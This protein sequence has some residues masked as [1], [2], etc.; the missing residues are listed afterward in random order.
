MKATLS[1][2]F[3]LAMCHSASGAIKTETVSV[4]MRDGIKLAPMFI[5]M[6]LL[7][8]SAVF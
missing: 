7:N 3:T 1:V 2:V 4:P 6:T 8:G 5:A